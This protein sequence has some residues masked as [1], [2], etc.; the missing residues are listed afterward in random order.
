MN[1]LLKRILLFMLLCG[2]AV[3]AEAVMIDGINYNLYYDNVAPYAYVDRTQTIDAAE[4]V[5]PSVVSYNNIEYKVTVLD[6]G[7]FEGKTNLKSVKLPETITK[8]GGHSFYGCTS[9]SEINIPEGVLSIGANCFDSCKALTSLTLPESLETIESYAFDSCAGLTSLIVP[10]NV[11]EIGY[12]VFYECSSLSVVVLGAGVETIGE[13]LF[14]GSNNIK[15]VWVKSTTPPVVNLRLS[16]TGNAVVYVP[17]GSLAAYKS[18]D[19]WKDCNLQGYGPHEFNETAQF[20]GLNFKYDKESESYFIVAQNEDETLNYQDLTNVVIP[21]TIIVSGTPYKVGGI[22]ENA[23]AGSKLTSVLL[24]NSIKSIPAGA[25][26]NC[27]GLTSIKLPST[28]TSIGNEAFAGCDNIVTIESLNPV[29]PVLGSD[30]F[31]IA[32]YDNAKLSIL[33]DYEEAYKNAEG[34]NKFYMLLF[35]VFEIQSGDLFYRLNSQS[36]T[37]TV[38]PQSEEGSNYGN[39]YG[40]GRTVTIPAT[41]TY[42][43]YEFKITGIDD[44]AFRSA[45]IYKLVIPE[46]IESIGENAFNDSKIT[47]VDVPSLRYWYEKFTV[48]NRPFLSNPGKL[49]ING[50]YLT[51]VVITA[52]PAVPADAFTGCEGIT[53][54]E[55]GK[56]ITEFNTE[57]AGMEKITTLILGMDLTSISSAAVNGMTSLKT[58]KSM[59]MTAPQLPKDAFASNVYTSATLYVPAI[60]GDS[61]AAAAG[62]LQ[63]AKK[64]YQDVSIAEYPNFVF[65]ADSE[66]KIV[67]KPADTQIS[68]EIA[69]PSSITFQGKDYAISKAGDFTNCSQITS[70]VIPSTLR[71]I[72]SLT[73]CSSLKKIVLPSQTGTNNINPINLFYYLFTLDNGSSIFVNNPD[74][75]VYIDDELL[76]DLVFSSGFKSITSAFSGYS[77]LASVTISGSVQE[78]GSGAFANCKNL[79]SMTINSGNDA[80]SFSYN[81]LSGTNISKLYV[82]RE[83][84]GAEFSKLESVEFGNNINAIGADMFKG[85]EALKSVTIPAS[86]TS[87]GNSAFEGCTS[88]SEIQFVGNASE[89]LIGNYAFKSTGLKSVTIPGFVNQLGSG[90]FSSC[91]SLT[92][93]TFAADESVLSVGAG[94]FADSPVKSVYYGRNLAISGSGYPFS[95]TSEA[96]DLTVAATVGSDLFREANLNS[97]TFAKG[98]T[99]IGSRAFYGCS[100]LSKLIIPEDVELIESSAF[101]NCDNLSELEIEDGKTVLKLGSNAFSTAA[102]EN[103]YLG[104]TVE[105]N[106]DYYYSGTVFSNNPKLKSVEL[107]KYVTSLKSNEFINCPNLY[108]LTIG[109]GVREIEEFAVSSNQEIPKV[110]WLPNTRPQ[111]YKFING[112]VNYVSQSSY[113]LPNQKEYRNLSSKFWVNGVLYVFNRQASDRTCVAIDCKYAPFMSATT[114]PDEVEYGGIK[115]VVEEINEYAFYKNPY[116]KDVVVGNNVKRIGDLAFY[117]CEDVESVLIGRNTTDVGNYAFFNCGNMTK[118]EIGANT[119]NVGDYSFNGCK[120]LGSVFIPNSVKILGEWAFANCESLESAIVGTGLTEI[121]TGCFSGDKVLGEFMV[122]AGVMVIQN[123]VFDGCKGLKRFEVMDRNTELYLGYSEKIEAS[124]DNPV[125][126][127]PLF[128][129]AELEEVYIGG[130]ISYSMAVEDGYSPF[131]R[132]DFL[133]KVTIADNETEISNYEFYGCRNLQEV[134]IGNGVAKIGDYAFSGCIELRDF[135]FGK[136]VATIGADAFSDCGNMKI[137]TSHRQVPPVCAS[138]ALDDIDKF[139]CTLYVPST[140]I[141]AYKNAEQWKNFFHIEA[142]TA[143]AVPVISMSFDHYTLSLTQG[144]QQQIETTT[145]PSNATDPTL[146]WESDNVDVAM[147]SQFGNI[148]AISPGTCYITA[149]TTDGSNISQTCFVTV[150]GYAGVYDVEVSDIRVVR[151]GDMITV[152]GAGVNDKVTVLNIAGNVVYEGTNKTIE[153]LAK[154]LHIVIVDDKVFKIMM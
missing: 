124:G 13:S 37:G 141:N 66:G 115:F 11:K 96:F 48:Q 6:W 142:I 148:V 89:L 118:L 136:E 67:V 54:L 68:G 134:F 121:R 117:E 49:Q 38:I 71:E 144:E 40:Y 58:V 103:L 129:D 42:K 65:G 112:I 105:Y 24:S 106:E 123:Q 10:D 7:C 154:G 55:I 46:S 80:L 47:I 31:P 27:K 113:D 72:G 135:S 102:I 98:I 23:F 30:V 140:S 61:Y 15:E 76:T 18:A 137:L 35:E 77:K 139:K 22:A 85:A 41:V 28:I 43:D 82:D 52:D 26:R 116:S 92:G 51:S 63:F 2:L 94:L 109:V 14:S 120:K 8:L 50:E 59:N 153:R 147:V 128:V 57:Y 90:A 108:S 107:G 75:E 20:A 69:I 16:L 56:G 45:N 126:G 91:Q 99:T 73:G 5:I 110:I 138:Q 133:K 17:E 86:I 114:V 64:D 62:W 12:C 32:V 152:L 127:K 36:L 122:P 81:A 150:S 131:Y 87:I 93:V 101:E 149:T 119:V 84:N 151:S 95:G 132:N 44:N 79:T 146:A 130:N 25:F 70:I 143:V 3:D 88:L 100:A 125:A 1:K 34:W 53:S 33:K 97:V 39:L 60:G 29:P 104:R 74:L 78:V 19:I 83:I 21:E 4:I 9:L 145:L 111:G